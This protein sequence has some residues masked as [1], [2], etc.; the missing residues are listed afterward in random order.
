M[1]G[2]KTEH[3]DSE[4]T[5]LEPH[6]SQLKGTEQPSDLTPILGRHKPRLREVKKLLQVS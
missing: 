6:E 3:G 5:V 4:A 2:P 1:R